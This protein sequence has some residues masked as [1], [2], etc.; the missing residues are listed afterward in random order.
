MDSTLD[1]HALIVTYIYICGTYALRR[2]FILFK[3]KNLADSSILLSYIAAG[4][5]VFSLGSLTLVLCSTRRYRYYDITP[6]MSTSAFFCVIA[7]I[8]SLAAAAF[9]IV[10]YLIALER[11]HHDGFHANLGPAVSRRYDYL[12]T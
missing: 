8:T 7:F 11:F 12:Y 2:F 9:A 10:L 1:L 3:A 4:I 6:A 5:T